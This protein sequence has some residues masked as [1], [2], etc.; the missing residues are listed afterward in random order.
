MANVLPRDF[1]GNFFGVGH[2][3]GKNEH[4]NYC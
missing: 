4:L 2:F 3:S 1:F